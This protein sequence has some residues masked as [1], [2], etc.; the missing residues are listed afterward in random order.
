MQGRDL[1]KP[2][3]LR[4]ALMVRGDA[5]GTGMPIKL[6]ILTL[7]RFLLVALIDTS[8]WEG[9]GSAS[10]RSTVP[11]QSGSSSSLYDRWDPFGF[12]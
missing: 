9:R 7:G 11:V 3:V 5:P 6:A 8:R 10:R 12:N 2:G 4:G 1:T